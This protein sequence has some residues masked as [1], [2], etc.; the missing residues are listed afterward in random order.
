[1]EVY[2]AVNAVQAHLAGT[3]VSKNQQNTFDKYRFRGIDDIYNALAPALA[4]HGLCVFPRV[5]S[6]DCQERSSRDGKAM[7]YV[8]VEVE[9]DFVAMA[10]GS[11]HTV[12]TFGEAMDRSDKATNKAM[13]AAYK[14]ACFQTFCIPTEGDND[15]DA[16][17]HEVAPVESV[18][19]EQ[20]AAIRKALE[21]ADYPEEIFITKCQGGS[22]ESIH[23]N[24]FESVI[25]HIQQK[26]E[27]YAAA[28]RTAK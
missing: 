10:D 13:S 4:K 26:G 23:A 14:Y 11:K 24:Q 9:F 8:T 12:K 16:N 3:G 25:K 21:H 28:Q 18:S 20:A 22:V 1:M 19:K 27:E 2:K 6:R 15:A 5:L 17:T 7:F